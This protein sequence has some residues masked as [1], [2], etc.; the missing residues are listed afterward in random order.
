MFE[1]VS[2][3]EALRRG[4][5]TVTYPSLLIMI[6]LIVLSIAATALLKCGWLI[7]GGIV[8]SFILAW[9]YWGFAITRWRLWAFDN[10][11]N[12]HEL[13]KRAI[14][15]Q[16]IWKDGSIFEKTEIRSAA[17]KDKWALLQDKFK[18][19]DIFHDDLTV[20]AETLIHYSKVTA[21]VEMLIGVPLFGGGVYF[22]VQPKQFLVAAIMLIAGIVIFVLGCRHYINRAAQITLS[23]EGVATIKASFFNWDNVTDEDTKVEQHGKSSTTYFIYRCPE[24]QIKVNISELAVSRGN[25]EKLLRIYRGR[26]EQKR[27]D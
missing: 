12:V 2:V 26:W 13:K 20:P 17:D 1:T 16:L 11:R 3:D 15:A 21:M 24:G 22:V 10:V 23:N 14:K 27:R 7:G 8:I 5:R 25:L 4:K 6:S 19:A 9:L 18:L